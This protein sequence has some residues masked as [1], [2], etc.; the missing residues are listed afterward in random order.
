[1]S[2]RSSP[3]ARNELIEEVNLDQKSGMQL[4]WPERLLP[5]YKYTVPGWSLDQR[6]ERVDYTETSERDVMTLN[7]TA[8]RDTTE[9]IARFRE[10]ID[11]LKQEI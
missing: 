8:P 4:A 2:G 5:G 1:M 6:I 3:G 9:Q 10:E 11:D 7:F